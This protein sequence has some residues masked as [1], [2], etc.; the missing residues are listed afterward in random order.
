MVQRRNEMKLIVKLAL[1]LLFLTSAL[2]QAQK[3][4][5]GHLY[6][7]KL[8]NP[9]VADGSM[10][11]WS[12]LGWPGGHGTVDNEWYFFD[13]GELWHN[14]QGGSGD[15]PLDDLVLENHPLSGKAEPVASGF[16]LWGVYL[17]YEPHLDGHSISVALDLPCSSNF[18]V[19]PEYWHPYNLL[20]PTQKVFYP[21]AFDCDGNGDPNT[22]NSSDYYPSGENGFNYMNGGGLVFD[23]R[24]RENYNITLGLGSDDF[25]A[26]GS[27]CPGY[28]YGLIIQVELAS[29]FGVIKPPT[30]IIP[31]VQTKSGADL[32]LIAVYGADV[33]HVG[34][35][36]NPDP[37]SNPRIVDIEVKLNKLKTIIEDSEYIDWSKV[38]AGKLD[39]YDLNKIYLTV[40]SGSLDDKSDEH[41]VLGGHVFPAYP[42][43]ETK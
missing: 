36:N 8:G 2:A 12:P 14:P 41:L 18:S 1:V 5:P 26:L 38:P 40:K 16:N 42:V 19:S 30:A 34:G 10:E 3:V 9:K 22:V 43:S 31:G 37:F 27:G 32:D 35:H 23:D 24:D 29:E 39:I 21:V 20:P 11:E 33:L 7:M 17:C 13:N 28:L 25:P 6:D 15:P 4:E